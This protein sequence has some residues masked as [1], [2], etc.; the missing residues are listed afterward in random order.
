MGRKIL[1]GEA[2]KPNEVDCK[3]LAKRLE[4]L[5][6]LRVHVDPHGNWPDAGSIR[7][8][9]PTDR[10]AI[11]WN[12]DFVER[13]SP[14]EFDALCAH[15][16]RHLLRWWSWQEAFAFKDGKGRD[17]GFRGP[18]LQFVRAARWL[19]E[20]QSDEFAAR[21]AGA[22]HAASMLRAVRAWGGE[23]K[24]REKLRELERMQPHP[25]YALRLAFLKLLGLVPPWWREE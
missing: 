7:W 16:Y 9:K 17:R 15:E 6:G 19:F 20:F 2:T 10:A 25:P 5:G 21:F 18:R 1:Q 12:S 14:E 3:D 11:L 4:L 23:Q 24:S 8:A 13:L 22:R